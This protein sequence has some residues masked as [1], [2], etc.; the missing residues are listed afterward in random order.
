MTAGMIG[1]IGLTHLKV[2][3]QRPGPDGMMAGCA[4]V[5]ALTEE[6]YLC[7]AGEGAIELHDRRH[8]FRTIPLKKGDYVQFPPGT[9]HRSV[10]TDAVEVIAVMGNSGLP[11][12]GDA[13]IYFGPEV[14]A[15]PAEFR[16]LK[17]LVSTG[18]DG[19]LDRRDA[20]ARAYMRL[21]DL[22]E[23]D[24]S[25]Y[26]AELD[27]FLSVH[28]ADLAGRKEAFADAVLH[29]AAEW[30]KRDAARL[31]ALPDAVDEADPVLAGEAGSRGIVY[32]MCG[33]LRQVDHLA[34]GL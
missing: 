4:H 7:I 6:A 21:L 32:G 31:A 13:R 28:R 29:G 3:D 19:A 17:G 34:A 12:R 16:R 5:H 2:Y 14:D 22:W 8:G 24:R 30:A 23:R 9:L 26:E 33:V 25:G 18:L 10:S 20:S 27:R 15:D 1:G 11:E